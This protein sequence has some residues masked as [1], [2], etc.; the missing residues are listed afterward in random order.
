MHEPV[1]NM[2]LSSEHKA[3]RTKPAE[4]ATHNDEQSSGRNHSLQNI[5]AHLAQRV[6]SSE[7]P[8][9]ET[10]RRFG[11]NE[12]HM[13]VSNNKP[14]QFQPVSVDHWREH[15]VPHSSNSL[16]PLVP[17]W[18][19]K[20]SAQRN[21]NEEIKFEHEPA[22]DVEYMKTIKKLAVA[23]LL[24]KSELV[25]FDGNPLRYYVSVNSKPDHPPGAKPPGNFFDGGFP[26]PWAKRCS[27]PPPPG[28]IKTS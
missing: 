8:T 12:Y 5:D 24:P 17:S 28:P 3:R 14:V 2:T 20:L 21:M 15:V 16:D 6:E 18:N 26:T 19:P 1:V 11:C 9:S 25:T 4:F 10:Y 7:L 23:S 13:D 27:K 22:T